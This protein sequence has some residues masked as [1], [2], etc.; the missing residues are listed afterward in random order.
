MSK[1]RAAFTL[2]ELLVVIAIIGILVALLLPAVQAAREAARRNTCQ[3][4]EKQLALAIA[5]YEV[6]RKY[7][8]LASTAPWANF[9]GTDKTRSYGGQRTQTTPGTTL[10]QYEDGYSWLVI[11]LPYIEEQP[12]FDKISAESQKFQL[13]AFA[14]ITVDGIA[15]T[16]PAPS[17]TNYFAW[18]SNIEVLRCPSYPGDE[19]TTWLNGQT[20]TGATGMAASADSPGIAVGNYV[21]L[22]STHYGGAPASQPLTLVSSATAVGTGPGGH[23]WA[24]DGKG[25]AHLG[26]GVL[27]F[28]GQTQNATGPVT[29]TGL[30]QQSM[31]DGTSKTALFCE[32]IEDQIASWYSGSSA[33][34]VGVW[35]SRNNDIVPMSDTVPKS[36][37]RTG[38]A[39]IGRFTFATG[40]AAN[41]PKAD[42]T[43]LNRGSTK[44]T[45]LEKKKWYQQGVAN[46]H[47]ATANEANSR[48]W[49]PS[50]KHPGVVLHAFGDGHVESVLETVDGDVYMYMITRNGREVPPSQQ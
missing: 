8:P 42:A 5:N 12:L 49:G 13:D 20:A 48:K 40:T 46:P 45:D 36:D 31:T 1:P 6:S 4:Q 26:N 22:P 41:S 2:V 27:V 47:A 24:A 18:E 44:S 3:S 19:V 10:T 37:Q 50:S 28:P 14:T 9:T 30:G 35:P 29:K 38:S 43:A 25:K 17:K 34:V 39:N 33:Y 21:A 7:Y 23:T 16:T 32:S 11:L 15:G